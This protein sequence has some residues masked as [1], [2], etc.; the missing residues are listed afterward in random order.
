MPPITST[1]P[2]H[3]ESSANSTK[4]HFDNATKIASA[5]TFLSSAISGYALPGFVKRAL[6]NNG[7]FNFKS[8]KIIAVGMAIWVA[9]NAVVYEFAYKFNQK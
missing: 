7:G 9:V 4:F 6:S 1:K 8:V 2:N 3:P 5:A